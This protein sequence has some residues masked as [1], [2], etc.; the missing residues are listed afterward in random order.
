MKKLVSLFLL[1]IVLTVSGCSTVPVEETSPAELVPGEYQ[2]AASIIFLV[3]ELTIQELTIELMEEEEIVSCLEK[4]IKK[5]NPDQTF[6]SYNQFVKTMFPD[7]FEMEVSR[8]PE[9][10]SRLL[11]DKKFHKDV[12]SWGIRY[13]I[14]VGGAS[15]S[16]GHG[17]H[18]ALAE[19]EFC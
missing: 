9:S 1:L 4:N 14:F 7:L 16:I 11:A 6:I 3:D 17:E 5:Q 10:Y 19:V 12:L 13:L 2:N 15:E 8:E 18:I